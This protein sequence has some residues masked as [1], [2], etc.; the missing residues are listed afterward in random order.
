LETTNTAAL[1]AGEDAGE[2]IFTTL[3]SSRAVG[4]FQINVPGFTQGAPIIRI[5]EGRFDVAV[6]LDAGDV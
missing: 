3:S 6:Q 5:T 1:P 4:T 2:V